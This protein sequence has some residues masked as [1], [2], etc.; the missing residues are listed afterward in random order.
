VPHPGPTFAGVGRKGTVEEKEKEMDIVEL[1]QQKK[2]E[3]LISFSKSTNLF[4]AETI[5]ES[6]DIVGSGETPLAAVADL[7]GTEAPAEQE[8]DKVDHIKQAID[9]MQ[10]FDGGD[11]DARNTAMLASIAHSAIAITDQLFVIRQQLKKM[12]GVHAALN[13]IHGILGVMR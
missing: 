13:N 10:T 7:L 4:Y 3:I 8:P 2:T 9:W 6:G 12:D 5:R 11:R 1:M